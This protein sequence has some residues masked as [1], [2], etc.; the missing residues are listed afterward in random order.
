MLGSVMYILNPNGMFND[1]YTGKGEDIPDDYDIMSLI[2]H[3]S[4][5]DAATYLNG[6]ERTDWRTDRAETLA[7]IFLAGNM[8]EKENVEKILSALSSFGVTEEKYL[9]F[10]YTY[11]GI[12]SLAVN[13]TLTYRA[14]YDYELGLL[15]RNLCRGRL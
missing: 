15:K 3:I 5:G 6:E 13:A 14:R 4:A 11:A 1:F 8:T 12:R 7:P 10:G 9:D 2:T